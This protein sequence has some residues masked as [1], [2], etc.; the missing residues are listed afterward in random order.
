MVI[1]LHFAPKLL[2]CLSL[3]FGSYTL[4]AAV[5]QESG[6]KPA[7]IRIAIEGAYPPFNY[8]DQANELQGFEVDL[9]KALCE[10]MKAECVIVQHEWDGIIRG[11]LNHEYDAIMSSLE[12]LERRQKRLAFS[13]PYYRIPAIFIAPKNSTIRN[14]TP[15]GLAGS[16]IGTTIRSD[17][18]EYLE[19]HYKESQIALY[20]SA[21][22]ATLDL[23]VGRVDAVFGD[24]RAL[25]KFLESRE[26][27]CC[28]IL[29]TAP[30]DPPYSR[31]FYGIGLRKEDAELKAR[32]D[33]ALAAIQADGT[34]DRVRVKYFP[35]DIK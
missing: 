27:D 33:R 13:D 1:R 6:P 20:G 32:F 2:L 5:A 30:D 17:Y 12:I 16:K 26:G 22:E 34:Y 11:L 3:A 19:Q 31:Q 18:A 29:G 21:M 10:Q 25:V 14:L 35:F 4:G 9:A 24:K 23:L 15:E 28:R 8:I 7:P